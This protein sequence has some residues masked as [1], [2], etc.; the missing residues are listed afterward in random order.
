MKKR[1]PRTGVRSSAQLASD[2]QMFW[3]QGALEASFL[4]PFSD[5][6]WNPLAPDLAERCQMTAQALFR[7]KNHSRLSAQADL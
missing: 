2:L 4:C 5:S 3:N 1:F 7:V 6:D